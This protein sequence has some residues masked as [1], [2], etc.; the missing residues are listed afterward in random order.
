MTFDKMNQKEIDLIDWIKSSG[1]VHEHVAIA[2][3]VNG[4]GLLATD[5]IP[6]NT[7]IVKVDKS[8]IIK[9]SDA[10][11]SEKVKKSIENSKVKLTPV[12][13]LS[14]FIYHEANDIHQSA[15]EKYLSLLPGKSVCLSTNKTKSLQRVTTKVRLRGKMNSS[16][17]YLKM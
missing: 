15:Y 8:C 1:F 9:V 12:E 14:L 10:I 11:A 6:E 4:R 2:D 7:I 5:D 13:A 3:T 17:S 16:I